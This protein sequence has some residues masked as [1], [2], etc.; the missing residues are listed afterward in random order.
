VEVGQF[1]SVTRIPPVPDAGKVRTSDCGLKA[2]MQM[3]A[4]IDVGPARAVRYLILGA[5]NA[6]TDHA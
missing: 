5:V 1:R 3:G 2:E 4:A 6:Y